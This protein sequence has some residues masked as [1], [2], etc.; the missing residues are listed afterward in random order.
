[1]ANPSTPPADPGTSTP[2]AGATNTPAAGAGADDD[3]E[4]ADDRDLQKAIKK[5]QAFKAEAAELRAKL[6]EYEDRDKQAALDKAK[7]AQDWATLE[8]AKDAELEELKNKLA[9]VEQ[10]KAETAKRERAG[11][12]TDMVMSA[13]QLPA[14]AR[15]IVEA[16]L[17]KEER[18]GSMDIAPVEHAEALAKAFAKKQLRERA[19]LLFN[20]KKMGPTGAAGLPPGADSDLEARRAAVVDTA[21]ALSSRRSA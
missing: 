11:K 8:K 10:E 6:K 7:A 16:I 17:I 3:D 1:M 13:A 15:G 19:P 20:P 21:K 4:D 18:D 2:P 9:A 5:R 14:E 12:F